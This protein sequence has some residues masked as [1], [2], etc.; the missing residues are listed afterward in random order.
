[1]ACCKKE[2]YVYDDIACLF[3]EKAECRIN[4][5]EGKNLYYRYDDG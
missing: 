1:M 5:R 3:E 4:W 2:R